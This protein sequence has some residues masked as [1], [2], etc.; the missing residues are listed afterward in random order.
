MSLS[1]TALV[2]DRLARPVAYCSLGLC[3]WSFEKQ[4]AQT[5]SRKSFS[6]EIAGLR[7][8]ISHCCATTARFFLAGFL[9]ASSL[10]LGCEREQRKFSDVAPSSGRPAPVRQTELQP[11]A[12][13][14]PSADVTPVTLPSKDGEGPFD[15]NAWAGS[16]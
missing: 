12:P 13:G 10:L 14:A 4:A 1:V 2:G 7:R 16:A 15:K 6:P 3:S 8:K 5:S 11:G 9:L